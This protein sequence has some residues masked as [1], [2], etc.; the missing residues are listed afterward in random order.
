MRRL[1]EDRN[2]TT[3]VYSSAV[4]CLGFRGEKWLAATP[5]RP[6]SETVYFTGMQ[7]RCTFA[8]RSKQQRQRGSSEL[9]KCLINDGWRTAPTDGRVSSSPRQV[10]PF[11]S[12]S[13]KTPLKKV[14]QPN[15]ADFSHFREEVSVKW[16]VP[17]PSVVVWV[18]DC[19]EEARDLCLQKGRRRGRQRIGKNHQPQSVGMLMSSSAETLREAWISSSVHFS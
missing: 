8:L 2:I 9:Y 10:S 5:S 3:L 6:S 12:V 4:F 15:F 17:L 7:R 11:V 18:S 16:N 1:R 14:Q 13:E 19:S